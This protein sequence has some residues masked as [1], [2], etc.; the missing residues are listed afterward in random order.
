MR[1]VARVTA[2]FLYAQG[3]KGCFRF[4]KSF[5]RRIE[6]VDWLAESS[7]SCSIAAEDGEKEY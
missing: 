7:E 5:Q 4:R 3:V 6:L 2:L 1:A